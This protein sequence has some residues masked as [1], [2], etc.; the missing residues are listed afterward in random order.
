MNRKLCLAL[1]V[2]FFIPFLSAAEIK[3]EDLISF[4]KLITAS[5]LDPQLPDEPL[6]EWVNKQVGKKATIEWQVGNF[7]ESETI[8]LYS[9]AFIV[10]HPTNGKFFCGIYVGDDH[11]GI[12]PRVVRVNEVHIEKAGGLSASTINSLSTFLQGP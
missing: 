4:G 12:D 5:S 9:V 10:S 2:L 3:N 6:G 11:R 8:A 7:G 1:L